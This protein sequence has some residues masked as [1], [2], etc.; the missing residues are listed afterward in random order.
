MSHIIKKS[1]LEQVFAATN[2]LKVLGFLLSHPNEELYDRE[3]SRLTRISPAGTNLALRELA[4]VSLIEQFDKGRMKFYRLTLDDPLIRQIK[5]VK[6]LSDLK[7][8]T[9]KLKSFSIRIV[10]FGSAA[11]GEDTQT[12]DIDLFILAREKKNAMSAVEKSPLSERLKPVICTPSEWA[13]ISAKNE[14]FS[15]EVE[16]GIIL[17][18]ETLN[19]NS[20]R[21]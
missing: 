1:K 14:V 5:I 21:H 7:P 6:T 11:V 15:K 2:T 10:L 17:W 13:D 3:I 16:K 20:G 4:E 9:E 19:R 18:D 12:S 8:L